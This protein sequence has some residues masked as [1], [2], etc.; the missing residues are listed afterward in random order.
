M[1]KIRLRCISRPAYLEK[2]AREFIADARRLRL[3]ARGPVPLPKKQYRFAMNRS[4]FKHNRSKETYAA[5]T[6]QRL[7]Y[8]EAPTPSEAAR[9]DGLCRWWLDNQ[10]VASVG[11]A[12]AR[13]LPLAFRQQRILNIGNHL[14]QMIPAPKN[15]RDQD[16]DTTDL[17]NVSDGKVHLNSRAWFMGGN[18]R[19]RRLERDA[20]GD[21]ELHSHAPPKEEQGPMP[22]GREIVR[23]DEGKRFSKLERIV[24]RR[25]HPTGRGSMAPLL[26][27]QQRQ[28]YLDKHFRGGEY[29]ETGRPKPGP[30]A[31]GGPPEA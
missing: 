2:A 17:F 14:C 10:P 11:M 13:D 21:G 19:K 9:A 15:K 23:N 31:G 29:A 20:R 24:R 5:T 7:I 3:K 18:T 6:R 28:I 25:R 4:V 12:V 26:S 22:G 16:V 1:Y 8:L 30:Y 27:G